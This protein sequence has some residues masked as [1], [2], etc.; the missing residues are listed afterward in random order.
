MSGGSLLDPAPMTPGEYVS[1]EEQ[2]R[3]LLATDQ[4]LFVFQGEAIVA[5]EAAAR[6]FGYRGTK[7]LNIVSGPYGAVFGNWLSEGG[8]QVEDLVTPF[9]R[10]VPVERVE[11]AFDALG[12]FD[13]VSVVHAE[14]A[15]G[16]VNDLPA[17]ARLARSNGALVVVDAVASVGA[18]PLEIDGWGLDLVVLSAQKALAGPSG[19]TVVVASEAAWRRLGDHPAPPRGSVL[20]LLDWRDRWVATD[21]SSLPVIPAHL[22]TRALG[23]AVSRVAGEGLDNVVLRH[24]AASAAVRAGAAPL[25]LEPWVS[26]ACDAAAVATVLRAGE[27]QPRALVSASLAL[28]RGASVPISV[29]PGPLAADALRVNHTGRMATLPVVALAVVSLA[30]GLRSLGKRPDLPG[31]LMAAEGAWS[32]AYSAA[33][34]PGTER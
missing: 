33:M 26:E 14:A 25:G 29:A 23:E 31:A 32:D 34:V 12:P 28:S 1:V 9:D 6:G 20:S 10:A 3:A 30:Q 18:E 11:A 24:R 21:R 4:T 13:L 2:C 22:E 27:D 8:A 17:I 16:T 15:T 19:T 5:L 7:A